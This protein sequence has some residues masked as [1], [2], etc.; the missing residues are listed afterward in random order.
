[1]VMWRV[2]EDGTKG[3]A[4]PLPTYIYIYTVI[5]LEPKCP[6]F[7][8][9]RPSFRGKTKDKRVAGNKIQHNGDPIL[10]PPPPEQ[11]GHQ[12]AKISPILGPSL[13][14]HEIWFLK[15]SN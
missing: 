15:L 3:R 11:Q 8:W 1:M 6:L 9:K 7:V 10:I 14:V 5:Y 4:R 12:V 2:G 13:L